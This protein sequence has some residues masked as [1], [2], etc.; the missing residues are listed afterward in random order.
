LAKLSYASPADIYRY[1][2]IVFVFVDLKIEKKFLQ[3]FFWNLFFPL[4]IFYLKL[5]LFSK[6]SS[7]RAEIA[8]EIFVKKVS[9]S[10]SY[11]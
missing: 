11:Y 2:Q 10:K 3:E 5:T 8:I 4:L 7:F 9:L 1:L 6:C